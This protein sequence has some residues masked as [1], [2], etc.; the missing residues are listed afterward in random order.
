MNGDDPSARDDYY[1][2]RE[3][4]DVR[5]VRCAYV[6][7]SMHDTTLEKLSDQ[8]KIKLHLAATLRSPSRSIVGCCGIDLID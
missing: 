6:L 5:N 8:A 1:A 2:N 4:I 3:E 7:T